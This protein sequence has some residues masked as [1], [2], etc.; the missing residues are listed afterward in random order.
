MGEQQKHLGIGATPHDVTRVI[1]HVERQLAA[2]LDINDAAAVATLAK[3]IEN[4]LLPRIIPDRRY[5][6]PELE[7]FGYKAGIIYKRHKH[8]IRKDGRKSYIVGRDLI[9]LRDNAPTLVA[10]SNPAEPTPTRRPRGRPRKLPPSDPE[11][12]LPD[13]AAAPQ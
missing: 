13:D 1:K 8:L 5:D 4:D 7:Q 12:S 3:Q 9:A 6:I 11:S 10:N 2:G